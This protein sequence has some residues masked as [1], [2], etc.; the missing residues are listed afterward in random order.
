MPDNAELRKAVARAIEREHR[1]AISLAPMVEAAAA[2]GVVGEYVE[3]YLLVLRSAAS[4][5]VFVE[6]RES[7]MA[8]WRLLDSL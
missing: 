1:D 3:E 7:L 6:D 5:A 2:L 4:S 8:L